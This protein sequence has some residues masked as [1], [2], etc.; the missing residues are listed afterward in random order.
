[1]YIKFE[2]V[3]E[4]ALESQCGDFPEENDSLEFECWRRDMSTTNDEDFLGVDFNAVLY[5]NPDLEAP[6][7][8]LFE[9]F[10]S[11]VAG[12]NSNVSTTRDFVNRIPAEMRV[13]MQRCSLPLSQEPPT[14]PPVI[15]TTRSM[16]DAVPPPATDIPSTSSPTP[17]GGSA[18]ARISHG[19]LLLLSLVLMALVL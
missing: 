6:S 16:I 4:R 1:M 14:F 2:N 9:P 5:S 17:D 18:S 12:V 8:T 19:L 10:V 11:S 15:P 13:N 3:T 7:Q